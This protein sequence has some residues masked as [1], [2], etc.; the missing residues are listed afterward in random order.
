MVMIGIDAHK[1]SHT[2]VVIDAQGRELAQ[3]TAGTTL[4]DHLELVAWASKESAE[5]WWAGLHLAPDLDD[6]GLYD[7]PVPLD[8][9]DTLTLAY[10]VRF[11][12]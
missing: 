3:R 12:S 9:D 1:R 10:G 5:R 2:V 8:P 11:T 6:L 4:A 7:W